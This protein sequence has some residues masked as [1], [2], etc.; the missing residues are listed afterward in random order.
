MRCGLRGRLSAITETRAKTMK[1]GN[2]ILCAK[3]IYY[4][5]LGSI[6]ARHSVE[7]TRPRSHKTTRIVLVRLRVRRGR[8][9][10]KQKSRQELEAELR[11]L[12]HARRSE[13]IVTVVK[14]CLKYGTIAWVAWVFYQSIR[15]LAGNAT[16]A[17]IGIGFLGSVK[18]NATLGWTAGVLGVV[19]GLA[20]RKICRKTIRRLAPR[21]SEFEKRLDEKRSSSRLNDDGSTHPRDQ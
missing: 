18:I 13:A 14:D 17:D 19:Y 8:M 21:V 4:N 16:Y 7:T 12:R 10:K 3:P 9:A 1:K 2:C 11:I 6:R 15:C 5:K 20:Q